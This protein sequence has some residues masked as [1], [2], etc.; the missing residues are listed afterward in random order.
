MSTV[1]R[2]PRLRRGDRVR[3][4]SMSATFPRE[5]WKTG[6][7]FCDALGLKAQIGKSMRVDPGYLGR[8]PRRR[9]DDFNDALRDDS[10]RAIFLFRGGNSASEVLRFIDWSALRKQPKVVAGYSDHSSVVMA[11]HAQ[12]HVVTFLVP[13]MLNGP[14]P[15]RGRARLSVDTFRELAMDA[16]AGVELPRIQSRSWRGGR[17]RGPLMAGNLTILRNLMGTPYLPELRGRLLAWEDIGEQLQDLNVEFNQFANAGHFGALA[18]MVVGHLEGIKRKEEGFTAQD[19]LLPLLAPR[20]PVLK[21]GAFGHFRPCFTLPL[22]ATA[23]LD[24]GREHFVIEDAAV[25]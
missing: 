18:G 4:V 5:S 9:A 14:L 2:P 11:A 1:I 13:P 6:T 10:V 15:S 7:D 19:F 25:Q 17:A 16:R 3:V 8:D 22:G 21:T 23:S 12:T 20:A 24:A